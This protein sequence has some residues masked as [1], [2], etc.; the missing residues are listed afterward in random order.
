MP[1][2]PINDRAREARRVLKI[3]FSGLT[4]QANQESWAEIL[5]AHTPGWGGLVKQV[6]HK[7]RIKLKKSIDVLLQLSA[8]KETSAWLK[9]ELKP[10][11]AK[12]EELS[13]IKPLHG[14]QN[15]SSH[16]YKSSLVS[17]CREIWNSQHGAFPP[18]SYRGD[19]HP[20]TKFLAEVIYEVFEYDFS[21]RTAIES[22][23]K[24]E[25]NGLEREK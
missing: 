18:L 10:T 19:A 24:F 16:T 15:T 2:K 12:L 4:S 6:T 17:L 21:P 3:H 9:L 22:Y 5:A 11:L 14:M 8:D 23:Q 1:N 20:F 7:Q 13:S 25:K